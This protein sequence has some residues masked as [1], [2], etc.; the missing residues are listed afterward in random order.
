MFQTEDIKNLIFKI[1]LRQRNYQ[2]SSLFFINKCLGNF[3]KI[4]NEFPY[5]K[6]YFEYTQFLKKLE[7]M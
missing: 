6:S 2:E 1:Y 5:D 4:L 3:E 7:D